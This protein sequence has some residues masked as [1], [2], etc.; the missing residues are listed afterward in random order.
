[1]ATTLSIVLPVF[2]LILCGYVVGRFTRLLSDEAIRGLTNFV[3]YVAIPA[4]LFR[5][6]GTLHTPEGVSFDITFAYFGTALTLYAVAMLIGRLV[7]GHNLEQQAMFAMGCVFS[8][9]VL[10]G[11]PLVLTA[12]GEKA[13]LPLM[14]I[15]GVH[16]LILISLPT[17]L[18]E[19]HRGGGGRW[20]Q[21]LASAAVALA[22]N[23]VVIGMAAGVGW[24]LTGLGLNPVFEHFIE[25]LGRAAAP[26]A[27]FALGA[28]LTRYHLGGDLR[29]VGVIVV[30]KLLAMPAAVWLT[31]TYVF[32]IDPMWAAIAAVNAAMPDGAN[33]F[34]L[35]QKYN[36]FV[37]RAAAA[38]LISTAL[39]WLT[40][41]WLLSHFLPAAG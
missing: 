4:L 38:V 19:V 23:P 16:P 29:E 3:F 15:I 8:N 36:L 1:M 21:V 31:A 22:R 20:Y 17:I 27:L 34:V 14:M 5:T 25:L 12:F 24:G 9:S 7:F 10:L 2:G 33:V 30:F 6:L 13:L 11:I 32:A 18:I 41:A 37:A 26:C 35:A 39:A 40:A 28:S